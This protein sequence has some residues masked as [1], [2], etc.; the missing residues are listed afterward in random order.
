MQ[1]SIKDFSVADIL[2][3]LS[4]QQKTGVLIVSQDAKSA[5]IYFLN[6]QVMEVKTPGDNELFGVMLVKSK[7]VTEDQLRQAIEAQKNSL[8]H[9]CS[10]LL[11]QGLVNKQTY[12]H[13][14]LTHSYE[15][16]YDIL[17]WRSGAYQ[18]AAQDV[19]QQT[20]VELPGL[21]SILLD[22][23]RMID[24]W[25]EIKR[26]ISSFDL[27]F[28]NNY[29]S[30]EGLDADEERICSLVDGRRSVQDIID[31]GL[32]GRFHTCKILVRLVELG[33]IRL[34]SSRA[35]A[36]PEKINIYSHAATTAIACSG[37]AI[38]LMLVLWLPGS[39][40]YSVLPAARLLRAGST[41]LHQCVL[42]DDL[43]K[44]QKALDMF[45]FK[46][47]A[48]PDTASELVEA[49]MLSPDDV[50][51]FSDAAVVYEKTGGAYSI[52]LRQ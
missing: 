45:Y 4:Q 24:E 5:E 14:M 42:R 16:F 17:Q 41:E 2:Q 48:Y 18:F 52:Q 38:F 39:F 35:D 8:E 12:E 30:L 44:I 46:T 32:L 26:V 20:S 21:E 3:L 7:T 47:G 33:G 34:L 10:I 23:L 28:D 1:G 25:P 13:L 43:L 36:G 31:A 19:P 6:G 22:V 49:G 9:I 29:A 37:L 15:I 51:V 40:L 27:L 50:A 11:R